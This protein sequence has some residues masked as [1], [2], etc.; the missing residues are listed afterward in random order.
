MGIAR[1]RKLSGQPAPPPRPKLRSISVV[2]DAEP[3]GRVLGDLY[4]QYE[5]NQRRTGQG[6]VSFGE[7]VGKMIQASMD[8]MAWQAIA[9]A[10]QATSPAG[11]GESAADAV[12]T[13]SHATEELA[14]ATDATAS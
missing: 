2:V 12:V 6:S 7:F 5:T 9:K 3:Y 13:G 11:G 8:A 1:R 4:D 10:N 14:H